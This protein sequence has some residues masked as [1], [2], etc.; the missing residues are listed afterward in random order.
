MHRY[1]IQLDDDRS[2]LLEARA[3]LA[4][5]TPQEFL[6]RSSAESLDHPTPDFAAA[7]EQVLKKNGELYKRLA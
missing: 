4:G 3:R 2:R 6:E 7:A 1:S 5:V